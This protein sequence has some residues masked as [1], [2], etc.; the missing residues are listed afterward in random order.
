MRELE[1]L[2]AID[3]ER[4]GRTVKDSLLLGVYIPTRR[5]IILYE[6]GIAWSHQQNPRALQRLFDVVLVHELAHWITHQLAMV[7]TETWRD[8]FFDRTE[9]DVL[10]GWA[11]LITWWIIKND[12]SL[13]Q[14]FLTLNLVQPLAYHI[15]K[16]YE[17]LDLRTMLLSLEQLRLLDHPAHMREWDMLVRRTLGREQTA[18]QSIRAA[19]YISSIERTWRM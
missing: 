14:S 13:R 16:R 8:G 10:E 3:R 1:R 11:Q 6:R 9:D 2:R 12:A 7:G 4:A 15:Y 19:R 5:Q 17:K 18:Y